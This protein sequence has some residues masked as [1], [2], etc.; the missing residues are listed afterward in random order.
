[1]RRLHVQQLKTGRLPLPQ[2]EAHHAR[3]V[4]RLVEGAPIELFD[5]SG[6]T[7]HGLIIRSTPEQVVVEISSI[8]SPR[9]V[10]L[11]WTVAA[12]IPKGNRADWMVEKLSEL[13][14]ARLIPLAAARSVVL[15][16]GKGKIARWQRIAAESAKQ[17]RRSGVMRF[18]PLTSAQDL[19]KTLSP[20]AWYFSTALD[21]LPVASALQALVHPPAMTLLIGPEGGW[22]E[23]EIELFRG[24]GLTGVS[25]GT[26]I[27]RVE[28]AAVA[29]G[30]I[31][32]ALIDRR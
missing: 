30:A 28:T 7:A 1:M 32:A 4:L 25:L 21:A 19:V 6:Q 8:D 2:R 15:P 31:A 10:N 17:S 14:C 13:G 11:E 9:P 27:L 12:A 26:T 29:A 20:P 22:T 23:E 5:S 3:D 16:D 24:T 18:E